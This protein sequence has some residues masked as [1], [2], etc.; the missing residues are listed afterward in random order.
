[1]TKQSAPSRLKFR[2]RY[3]F[4][5]FISEKEATMY[6]KPIISSTVTF[7]SAELLLVD[8]GGDPFVPMR[9]L[10]DGIGLNWKSQRAK[11]RSSRFAA[12]VVDLT[13]I[14]RVGQCREMP[15]LPLRKL[16][17]WLMTLSPHN[18]CQ[19]IRKKVIAYQQRCDDALWLH[20]FKQNKRD[21]CGEL[22]EASVSETAAAFTSEYL[23]DCRGAVKAAGGVV[24]GWSPITEERVASGMALTLL[25]N[26]RWLLTFKGEIPE[27]QQVPHNAGVFTPEKM[28][29]W[30]REQDGAVLSFLPDLLT[31]I[32]DR[33]RKAET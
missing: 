9:P 21:A 33:F 5:D 6:S 32:G 28:L 14:D 17:G 3:S 12:A 2:K 13:L 29:N 25:R 16:P 8:Y 7:H 15:C 31:A 24:P 10:V 4:Y 19:R 22:N 11:L 26:K 18:A 27:L 30:I 23:A 20:W 1:L